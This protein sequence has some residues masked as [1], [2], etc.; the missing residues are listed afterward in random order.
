MKYHD[1]NLKSN[2]NYKEFGKF[3]IHMKFLY[4][5]TLLIKYKK[6][7]APIP[8][9]RRTKISDDFRDAM[10]MLIDTEKIDY[11]KLRELS[12]VENDLFKSLI[13]KSGLFDTLKYN[14]GQTRENIKDVIE[15]YEILKGH[16]EAENNHPDIPIKIKKVLKKLKNYDKITEQEYKDI[17]DDL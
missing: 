7:Y 2:G 17:V 1:T 12:D 8:Q 15:E 14:Y 5:N 4:E 16:I 11:E 6:S 10:I 13:M 3:A 9:I